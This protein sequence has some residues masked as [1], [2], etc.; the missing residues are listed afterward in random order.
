MQEWGCT[1]CVHKSA[2]GTDVVR[3]EEQLLGFGT[4][5]NRYYLGSTVAVSQ[6]SYNLILRIQ[7][8]RSVLCQVCHLPTCNGA[9]SCVSA[10]T[11]RKAELSQIIL[12]IA[13]GS[14]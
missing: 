13:V 2:V 3:G 6:L 9:A 14:L 7:W 10:K 1:E 8:G 4:A 5:R 12:G 11:H